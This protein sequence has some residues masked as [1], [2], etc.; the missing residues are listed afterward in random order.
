MVIHG[1]DYPVPDG[2]GYL[3]GW[4][5]LPGPWLEPGFRR[6]GFGDLAERT[7]IMEV[8]I[9]RYNEMLSSV[10]G[11]APLAH[12]HYVN[13]RNT[14]P[15]ELPKTYRQWWND[16]LHPTEKGFGL[17]AAKLHGVIKTL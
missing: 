11:S 10:A 16:E 2:R 4:F 3:G 13:L 8:L 17:V 7:R 12:L 9:N 6:K 14:L 5:V 1:Y 15:N